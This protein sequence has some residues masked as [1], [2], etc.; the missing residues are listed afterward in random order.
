MWNKEDLQHVVVVIRL[1]FYLW[2]YLSF[3]LPFPI[4]YEIQNM[5]F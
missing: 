4:K 3:V 1:A 2:L 5:A